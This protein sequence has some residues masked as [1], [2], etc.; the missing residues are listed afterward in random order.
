MQDLPDRPDP[1]APETQGARP[2]QEPTEAAL[3]QAYGAF[4]TGVALVT[5]RSAQGQPAGLT[6]SSF[7]A[8]SLQ[9]PLVLW[10]LQRQVPP[11]DVFE[12]ATHYAVHILHAGQQALSDRFANPATLGHRFEGLAWRSG[13]AGLPLLH[14]CPTRLCCEVVQRIE[15]GDHLV[16]LGRVLALEH[17]QAEPLIYHAGRYRA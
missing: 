4:A 9:P 6:V 17:Q 13:T 10:C 5:T 12:Q 16:L 11:A 15:A 3:R 1:P 8:V 14:D 2:A 7:S